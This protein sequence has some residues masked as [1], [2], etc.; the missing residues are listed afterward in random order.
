MPLDAEGAD[1][2]DASE[3][4]AEDFS[5]VSRDQGVPAVLL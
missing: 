2:R 1:S 4:E 5:Q 3:E